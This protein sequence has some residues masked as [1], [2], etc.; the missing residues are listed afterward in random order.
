[1]TAEGARMKANGGR[2]AAEVGRMT[3]KGRTKKLEAV[4]MFS[5]DRPPT[6]NQY[7]ERKESWKFYLIANDRKINGK[8]IFFS[9]NKVAILKGKRMSIAAIQDPLPNILVYS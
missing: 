9:L 1:M 7:Q 5:E 8:I 6:E 2:M 3:A 4:L